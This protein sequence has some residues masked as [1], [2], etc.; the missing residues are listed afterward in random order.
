MAQRQL[1]RR[2]GDERETSERDAGTHLEST[3]LVK[4]EVVHGNE[5]DHQALEDLFFI[6][7]GASFPIRTWHVDEFADCGRHLLEER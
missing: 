1:M 5:F 3:A 4:A 2:Q 6:A 7:S